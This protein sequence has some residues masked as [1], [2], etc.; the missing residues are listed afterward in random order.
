MQS[1]GLSSSV[2]TLTPEGAYKVL[3]MAQKLER[4][5]KKIIHLEI[6]QPD[7]D[8]PVHIQKKAI[9]AI[10]KGQTKYTPPLGMMDIR[11]SVQQYVRSTRNI[12][13]GIDRIAITPSGKTAIFAVFASLINP[14]DEVIYPDPGF[15]TYR[16]LID[17]FGAVPKPIPLVEKNSFSFD[18]HAFKKALSKKTKLVIINSPSNPTG[19]VIPLHDLKTI[20]REVSKTKAFVMSDEMY[21][22]MTYLDEQYTSIFTLPHMRNRTFV[23]DG[24][25]KTYAMTGWRLGY[26][27]MPPGF[28]EKVDCFLTHSVGCT[29]SFTQIAGS[30]ALESSQNSVKK[31]MKEFRKRRDFTAHALNDIDRVTCQMPEGAFYV[32]PNITSFNKSSK[33]VAK[34][35][36]EQAGVALLDGT[37]F[38][39]FGEGYLRISY[40]TSIPVLKR[41]IKKIKKAL[42]K[43]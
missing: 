38:G 12:R 23:V 17:Y 1:P 22:Q 42:G 26:M 9:Q 16:A 31:M 21:S 8:T 39:E 35:L 13:V 10:S 33:Y 19:G 20:A 7:F 6:G 32:F 15:P 25:S 30:H 3:S 18:I 41:G 11:E 24:F 4:K 2:N 29:A 14:G 36:L 34:Y 5:G 37:S 43:L 28:T 40:A 27:I